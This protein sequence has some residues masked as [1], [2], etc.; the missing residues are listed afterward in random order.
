MNVLIV[1]CGILGSKIARMLDDDGH[2]VSVIAERE[3]DIGL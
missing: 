1:G 2:E 3:S